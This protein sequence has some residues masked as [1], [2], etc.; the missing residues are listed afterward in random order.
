MKSFLH[1]ESGSALSS[2]I[3]I[4]SIL[5]FMGLTLTL[6]QQNNAKISATDSD[7]MRAFYSAQSA[8]DY[9]VKAS[10]NTMNWHWS[11]SNQSIAG[12]TVT[13]TVEDN[14]I[15]P[16]LNDTLQVSVKS[17]YGQTASNQVFRLRMVDISGYA[18]YISGSLN[19]VSVRDSAGTIN[20]SLAYE[21][22]TVLPEIDINKLK[23]TAIAQG[24]YFNSSLTLDNGSTYPTGNDA[25]YYHPRPNGVPSDTPNV[26][27]IEGDLEV[28][29]SA[30]IYGIVVVQ[31]DVRL[32]NSQKLEGIL[33]LP[34][35]V[36]VVEPQDVTL[37]N[38]ENVYGGIF[39]GA[40]VEGN[41]NP[42]KINVYFRSSYIQKFFRN[43]SSNGMP[44]V[45]FWRNWKQ[46]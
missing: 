3:L 12:G 30:S 36:S 18:V 14:T 41:G 6:T 39:G 34:S 29:N 5:T 42:N 31:G 46:I 44:F 8:I 40:N 43:F 35:P 24:H 25:S 20:N 11:A 7:N 38:K 21:Y 10:L 16:A 15:R 2:T 37:Y 22:A 13:I 27:Y 32:K 33:Y 4:I 9:A 19:D 26:V 17:V 23:Q 1:D 28:K 45:M